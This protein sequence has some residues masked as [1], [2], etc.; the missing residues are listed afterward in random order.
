MRVW[1]FCLAWLCI[2]L[3]GHAVAVWTVEPDADEPF[4]EAFRTALSEVHRMDGAKE[5]AA[6]LAM[7]DEFKQPHEQLEIKYKLA[8]L[9]N[10]RTG[11]VCHEKAVVYF[12]DVLAHNLP[13]RAVALARTLCGDSWRIMKEYGKALEHYLKGLAFCL[14]LDLPDAPPEVPGVGKVDRRGQGPNDPAAKAAREE[15]AEQVKGAAQAKF[16]RDMIRY[17]DTLVR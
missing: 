1:A 14:E 3:P 9:Y 4:S 10:Q 2:V 15:H 13:P 12:E 11:M 8:I 7:L 5:E 6:L 17:R 16:E